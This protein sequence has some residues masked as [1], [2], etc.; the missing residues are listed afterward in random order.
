MKVTVYNRVPVTADVT[1]EQVTAY[2][3]RTGWK[4][5]DPEQYIGS[6]TDSWMRSPWRVALFAPLD[7]QQFEAAITRIAQAEG[8]ER[9]PGDVLVDI[10]G[11]P[12]LDRGVLINAKASAGAHV[13]EAREAL[14]RTPERRAAEHEGARVRLAQAEAELKA[15]ERALAAAEGA[16]RS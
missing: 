14:A 4:R 5:T 2:L 7:E 15:A 8:R 6:P 1:P 13:V 10:V 9:R 16:E 11:N 12:I 3:E